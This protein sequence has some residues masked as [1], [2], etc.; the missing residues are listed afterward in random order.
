MSDD[1]ATGPGEML[2]FAILSVN[3]LFLSLLKGLL[4]DFLRVKS[5]AVQ[6]LYASGLG[7]SSLYV[8]NLTNLVSILGMAGFECLCFC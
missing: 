6:V 7:L 3:V 8:G 5:L 1:R 2:S 4:S